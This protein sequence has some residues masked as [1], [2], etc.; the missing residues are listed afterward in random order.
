MPT[1]RRRFIEIG[2]QTLAVCCA[3]KAHA[4]NRS[5]GSMRENF[6]EE[7]IP[8]DASGERI[9]AGPAQMYRPYRSLVATTSNASTWVQIDLE[10]IYLID[11]VRLYPSNRYF[12]PGDGFPLRFLIEGSADEN[13]FS[14]N[15]IVGRNTADYPDPWDHILQFD[16]RNKAARYV[17]VTATA[18]R[19]GKKDFFPLVTPGGLE[20]S[21]ESSGR[22]FLFSLAK[23]E[24]LVAGRDVA[25]GKRVSVD[26]SL[27]SQDDAQQLTR[28]P[29]PQ[30]EGMITDTRTNV[31]PH[32]EW[33]SIKGKVRPPY[34]SLHL[35]G[36]LFEVAMRKNVT[37]LLNSFSVADLLRPFRERAGLTSAKLDHIPSPFW[38]ETLSGSNAGRFLMGA[39]TTLRWIDDSELRTRTNEL[40][41]GIAKF[42]RPDG[43]LMGYP[44]T[45]IFFSELGAYT[46]A[47]LTHGLIEV[48]DA[49]NSKAFSLLRDF[50][51]WYNSSTYLPQLL[52]R[53][54]QGGQ[55][56]V[57]N[58]RMYFTPLGKPVDIQ[59]VQRYFQENYWLD[60]LARREK[61][62]IWQYPYDRPHA[63]LVTNMEAYMDLYNAT[64]DER[65]LAAIDGG[66]ELVHDYWENVGGS[67]SIIEG[68]I[69]PPGSNKLYTR[70]GETCGS[71]FWVHLNHRLHVIRPDEEK[72]ITEIEKSIYNVVLANQDR[73]HGI[74]Y[75]TLLVG[76]KEPGSQ[77]NTCCEGQGARLIGSLPKYI[78]SVSDYDIYVNLFEPSIVSCDCSG[79][80]LELIMRT[81]FPAGSAVELEVRSAKPLLMCIRIRVPSWAAREMSIAVNGTQYSSGSPGTY[82]SL[83]REWRNGDIISFNLP[84]SLSL[85]K[86]VGED[87]VAGRERY[88]LEFGPFL[89]AAIGTE[90]FDVQL[91][92]S[93]SPDEI[94]AQLV[95]DPLNESHFVLKDS[96]TDNSS[97]I[98]LV[99]YYEI[100]DE[101]FT[102]FPIIDTRPDLL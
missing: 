22:G 26:S 69:D 48:G 14:S 97:E 63:Y 67:I 34:G 38:D 89:M 27:G 75:H 86:Y 39:G 59:V 54:M 51:D 5:Y 76:Q 90:N 10:S 87:K 28:H 88:S 58:T 19:R 94:V 21:S 81:R 23:V 17:R 74:R 7:K 9:C 12:A 49:G 77:V 6:P 24:V 62:A 52:R 102:C 57:A 68:D 71:S 93:S 64:G 30:G 82:V 31:T 4:T 2:A 47:W 25:L 65:Y 3:P 35:E 41:D 32:S 99:P 13:F 33:H 40:V 92:G 36:G 91:T 1:T 15:L 46:R 96:A 43:Y 84:I 8:P 44:E 61:R 80:T 100:L 78:Y 85:K 95:A 55:G 73:S 37:Y 11:S 83:N 29:R 45:D 66:W 50:Y 79:E 56:M 53:C 18:L 101:T 72:Y 70:L 42:R 16:G 98:R 20:E 60:D